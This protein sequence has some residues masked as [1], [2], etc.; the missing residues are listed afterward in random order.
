MTTHLVKNATPSVIITDSVEFITVTVKQLKLQIGI[1]KPF[2]TTHLVKNSTPSVIIT[3]SVKSTDVV[4][5]PPPPPSHAQAIL[6]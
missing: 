1:C 3:D 4:C 2:M 6:T 5:T